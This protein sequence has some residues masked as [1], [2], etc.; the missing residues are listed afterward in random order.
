MYIAASALRISSSASLT[1]GR[2]VRGE[3]DRDADARAHEHVL[4]GDRD[5]HLEAAHQALGEIDGRDGIAD[6]LDQ[7]RELVA[8]EA[9]GRVGRPHG[10]QQAD[11]DRLQHLVAG[12]V[13]EAVVDRLEVVEVEED[14]GDAGALARGA[15]EGVLDPVGEQR[16]VGQAGHGVV[17]RLV[18]QLL[19]ERRALA[20]VA[21]VEHD[22]ADVLVVA[23]VGRDD[24]ELE[25]APSR[26][27][28][29]QSNACERDVP[30]PVAC[31][32]LRR[33]ARSAGTSRFSK[34][35]PMTS[36]ALK[37]RMRWIDG[38]W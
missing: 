14:D 25:R 10:L 6:V 4:A 30:S 17:E 23:E 1:L 32:S 20:R 36:S 33:R 27:T 11:G 7:D 2:P 16:A 13:A 3:G 38:L 31:R 5:R 18:R 12:G 19:L 22:A 28:S 35:V 9:R 15:G 34:R 24:L 29:V 26:W 37:P 21:A 8:A